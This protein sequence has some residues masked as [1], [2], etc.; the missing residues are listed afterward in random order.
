VTHRGGRQV[1]SGR[2][3][4]DVPLLGHHLEEHQQVEVDAREMSKVQHFAE[5]I[6]L[7]SPGAADDDRASYEVMTG[8][9]K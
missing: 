7:A 9:P 3:A 1:Q 4:S 5:N 2:G 6:P 8:E